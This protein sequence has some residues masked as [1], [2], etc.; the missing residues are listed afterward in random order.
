MVGG[1]LRVWSLLTIAPRPTVTLLLVGRQW[2]R[3]EIQSCRE[4]LSSALFGRESPGLGFLITRGDGRGGDEG[5]GGEKTTQIWLCVH[6]D[7]VCRTGGEDFV[8]FMFMY[9]HGLG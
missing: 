7:S 8:T 2:P 5:K 3:E 9:V 4:V 6:D 1:R